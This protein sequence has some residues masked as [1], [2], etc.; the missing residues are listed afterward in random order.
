[1][2]EALVFP[3]RS[4]ARLILATCL[5]SLLVSTSAVAQS[6]HH[7]QSLIRVEL[8]PKN[9]GAVAR[10]TAS[11]PIDHRILGDGQP[12]S[13]LVIDFPNT[14]NDLK[15][16]FPNEPHPLVNRILMY[17][18]E[19]EDRTPRGRVVFDL[20]RQATYSKKPSPSDQLIIDL[21]NGSPSADQPSVSRASA[22]ER[23]ADD[24]PAQVL[25]APR[26]DVPEPRD[27]G[28][29]LA[30]PDD[31]GAASNSSVPAHAEI[32][33]PDI[34]PNFFFGNS[35]SEGAYPLG[36]EDV[37]EIH[38]FELEQLNRTV[39]V[40]GSGFINLPLIGR[41]QAGGKTPDEVAE[42]IAEKLRDG[43]VQNPQVSIFVK[44]F[45]SQTVS[46]LGAVGEPASYS[47]IGPRRLL[48][49]LAEAG[50]LSENAGRILFLFRPTDDG[51]SARLSVPLT[52]LMIE[53]DPRWNVIIRP[54]DVVSVPPGDAVSVSVLGAVNA[55]GVY[56]L[57]AGDDGTLLTAIAQA[58]GLSDRAAKKGLQIKRRLSDGQET[59]IKVNLAH[60]LAGKES[61]VLLQAGDVIV[62]KESF[63]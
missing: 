50:S 12:T 38:V 51:R 19:D 24:E 62:V 53:G 36:A 40:G 14:R 27:S 25:A 31:V 3:G 21:T 18:F 33:P 28:R 52:R 57:P 37:L 15:H 45:N 1:M 22:P 17:E 55:P 20:G 8:L 23:A 30:S 46:V 43:F 56:R 35:N 47:L 54:G 59:T 48:Q 4:A 41:V 6:R 29:T 58:G 34:D 63:F 2:N 7:T 39:R 9:N 16:F 49:I 60:I 44:E 10:I 32:V 42:Q 61:D 5:A 26:L 13:R 11:G